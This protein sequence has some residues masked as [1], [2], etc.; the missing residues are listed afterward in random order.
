MRF[1]I[2][3]AA[4]KQR[5]IVVRRRPLCIELNRALERSLRAPGVELALINQ[6]QGILDWSEV[7]AL[8]LSQPALR[9]IIELQGDQRFRSTQLFKDR[10]IISVPRKRARAHEHLPRTFELVRA[11][12]LSGNADD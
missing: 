8:K 10:K 3:L 1:L 12:S 11:R 2:L 5:K 6:S 4:I 7:R 9:F